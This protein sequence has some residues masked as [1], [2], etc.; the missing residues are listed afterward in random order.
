MTIRPER[1]RDAP[2]CSDPGSPLPGD[3]YYNDEDV[4]FDCSPPDS[5]CDE[6]CIF[7]DYETSSD[8]G[9]DVDLILLG[10]VP[11]TPGNGDSGVSTVSEER[12]SDLSFKCRGECDP[13]GTQLY[14]DEA[15]WLSSSS[16]RSNITPQNNELAIMTPE[17]DAEAWL[18]DTSS[19]D[20]DNGDVLVGLLNGFVDAANIS[21]NARQLSRLQKLMWLTSG[22]TICLDQPSE[23]HQDHHHLL[24]RDRNP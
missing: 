19:Y 15:A 1:Y 3:A 22:S 6:S 4:C 16:T 12:S 10:S 8:E 24:G 7:N 17:R 14:R 21:R 23:S 20:G 9:S 11:D 13:F 5:S 2:I 18:D